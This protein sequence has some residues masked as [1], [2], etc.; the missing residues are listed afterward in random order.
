MKDY[1]YLDANGDP[2]TFWQSKIGGNPYLPKNIEYPIDGITGQAMP[3]LIQI[4]CADV[5]PIAGFD[6]PQQGILQ[7]YLGFEP[8][9]A[10]CTP[11]KYRVLY[12]AEISE[13]ENDLI[14]DFSFIEDRGTIRDIYDDV[15]PLSFSVRHDLFWESRYGY[16]LE[17]PEEFAE[18]SQEFDEWILDYDYEY[19]TH[20]RGDKLGGYV[21]FYSNVNEIA[22]KAKGKLLLQFSHPFN[23]GD[24][25][26]FFIEDARLS[27][28][29][30]SK[31]EFYFVCD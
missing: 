12:F 3:L 2:L 11:E 19:D 20:L 4:N 1:S 7:F 22:E 14:T 25:F 26:Y 16:E 8:A 17:I 31:V 5:P 15:C 30:F 10:Q 28:C 6:F 27:N 24:S 29:D 21:D 13:D 18:L 9:H 23:I